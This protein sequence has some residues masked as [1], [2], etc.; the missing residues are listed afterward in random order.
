VENARQDPDLFL[1]NRPPPLI[2]DEIQYAPEVAS[3]I[4]RRVDKNR[5]NGQYFL[6]GSQQWAVMRSLADSLAGRVAFLDLD[7]FSLAETAGTAPA[8]SWLRAW[9]DQKELGAF[10]RGPSRFALYE[11]L[12]RGFLPQAQF[13][14]LE[15]MGAFF[16]GYE[17]TYIDR[18]VRAL[19]DFADLQTFGSFFRLLGALTA[20]EV[21]YSKLGREVGVTPQTAQRWLG[22]LR[23]TFQWFEFPA[24]SANLTKRVS[25]RAKGYMADTGLACWTQAVTSPN[26][27][28][29]HPLRGALFETAVALEIRKQ[30]RLLSTPPNIFHWRSH[31]GAE[32]DFLLE[33]DGVYFPIEAKTASSPGKGVLNGLEAL[34]KAHPSLALAPGL[35]IC[36]AETAY[37]IQKQAVVLP[38]DAST[39]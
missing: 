8:S 1:N 35:I 14:P 3:A 13:L 32:V 36:P 4:K 30:A 10:K 34:R 29:S 19:A 9:L 2:L 7:G 17:R 11:Q 33:K 25:A 16:Q 39:K 20:Q 6:S 22:I 15:A 24:F 18:D 12:W 37:P 26:A 28:A 38:C 5:Q 27:I 21:N 31:G 23:A